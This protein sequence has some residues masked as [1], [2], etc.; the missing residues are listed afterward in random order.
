M[1]KF[2]LSLIV[3][4][5]NEE[6]NIELLFQK[7]YEGIG[8]VLDYE[9]VIVDD[10]SQDKTVELAQH[11]AEMYSDK[12]STILLQRTPPRRGYGSVIRYG[13][14]FASGDYC[15]PV[16]ADV[17]D[18][19]HLIPA[20]IDILETSDHKVVQCNRYGQKKDIKML[21]LKNRFYHFFYRRIVK[22]LID[23]NLE[24]STYSFK[25]YDRK[26][27]LSMG[28]SSNKFSISPEIAFKMSL[29]NQKTFNYTHPQGTRVHGVSKFNFFGEGL[30]FIYVLIRAILHRRL[31]ILWF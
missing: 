21:P 24:D 2:K 1:K 10:A 16:S 13:L 7:I 5:L 20:F 23:P 8:D 15:I 22:A 26:V 12:F 17:V 19:I 27:L 3:P 14:A 30:G 4:C 25:M 18:P 31:G 29:A 11:F 6:D 28:I 9:V